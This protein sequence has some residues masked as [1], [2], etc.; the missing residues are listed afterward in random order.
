LKIETSETYDNLWT[1]TWG[2]QQSF[3]PV[4][5][6][7]RQQL[8]KLIGSLNVES[9]LDVGCGSGDNLAALAQAM[10]RLV[11]AGTDVSS[12][13]L[14]QAA[15]RVPGAT[16]RQLDIQ[17]EALNKQFDLVL[18][19]QVVEHLIDDMAAFRNMTRMAKRWVLVAT[20]RGRM[21]RSERAI[22]HFR[23]Y[24]DVELRAKA[25]AAGLRVVDVFGWGFPFYSPL[26]RTVIE[27]LPSGPPKG[28]L[29]QLQKGIANFLYSL[30]AFNI[31]RCGDVVTMLC[32]TQEPD[33][34][35][36]SAC[37]K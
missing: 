6:H 27:W 18:S 16:F 34:S 36:N 28:N 26:Y 5:R 4:H 3:G 23:N 35:Q 11:L 2:D 15:Q 37:T 19:N 22:G 33:R 32:E 7:Q 21:R 9:V 14:V 25:E 29:D 17:N 31:P 8:L 1:E 30:Y 12:Q 20:M 10:P 24:S 13:A